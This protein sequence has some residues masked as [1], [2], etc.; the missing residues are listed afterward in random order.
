MGCGIE[1]G[2]RTRAAWGQPGDGCVPALDF[3]DLRLLGGKR[4]R[5]DLGA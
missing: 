3:V 1:L 2:Q 5:R 4:R